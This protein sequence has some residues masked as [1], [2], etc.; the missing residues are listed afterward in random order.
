MP[1]RPCVG[2]GAAGTTPGY[3]A[4]AASGNSATSRKSRSAGSTDKVSGCR[5]LAFWVGGIHLPDAA[6]WGAAGWALPL[7]A[8][9]A[10]LAGGSDAPRATLFASGCFDGT[11]RVL[12][13]PAA[14]RAGAAFGAQRCS[15]DMVT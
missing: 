11:W 5:A 6:S 15:V 1:L 4:S 7:G 9:R 3:R 14:A 8:C 12:W 2:S 10:P 13:L